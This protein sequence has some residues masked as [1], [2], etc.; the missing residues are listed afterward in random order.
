[1]WDRLG[2]SCHMLI[3][4]R[5]YPHTNAGD[6][7]WGLLESQSFSTVKPKKWYKVLDQPAHERKTFG[8][9]ALGHQ[10]FNTRGH[11]LHTWSI[12]PL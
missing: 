11:N 5:L 10:N 9:L 12:Y 1:M 3:T 4:N 8:P 6:D 7:P 2:Y